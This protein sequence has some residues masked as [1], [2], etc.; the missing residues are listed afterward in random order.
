MIDCLIFRRYSFV[1]LQR[2]SSAVSWSYTCSFV[3]PLQYMF[4]WWPATQEGVLPMNLF[5]NRFS[6]LPDKRNDSLDCCWAGDLMVSLN[7]FASN[8]TF[9]PLA[10]RP[11]NSKGFSTYQKFFCI[12]PQTNRQTEIVPVIN[13]LMKSNQDFIVIWI[14]SVC[15]SFSE[16]W[17]VSVRSL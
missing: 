2:R 3:Y 1:G 17:C 12:L 8:A 5:W 15:I 16:C 6:K 7:Q 9:Y 14:S 10:P 4:S 11:T 13:G